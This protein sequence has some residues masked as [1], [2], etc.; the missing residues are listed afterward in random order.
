MIVDR[1]YENRVLSRSTEGTVIGRYFKFGHR[2]TEYRFLV[3]PIEGTMENAIEFQMSQ[4]TD[5]HL[6]SMLMPQRR[7]IM[8]NGGMSLDTEYLMSKLDINNFVTASVMVEFIR[9]RFHIEEGNVYAKMAE[10][11]ENDG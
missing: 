6:V 10:K 5:M 2:M 9:D 7:A 1:I 8:T 4:R 3:I 11:D